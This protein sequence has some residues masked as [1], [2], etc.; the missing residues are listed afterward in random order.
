MAT[1]KKPAAKKAVP[2]KKVPAKKVAVTK[3]VPAKKVVAKKA[4]LAAAPA[5]KVAAPKAA[6][7]KAAAA[8]KAAPAKKAAAP[9]KNLRITP[10]IL[11]CAVLTTLRSRSIGLAL[12]LFTRLV[13]LTFSAQRQTVRRITPP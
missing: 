5:K 7:V 11:N 10:L 8:K 2:A 9:A 1:A 3:A 4:A 13:K 12:D 6:P